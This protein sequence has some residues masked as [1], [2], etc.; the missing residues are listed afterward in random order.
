MHLCGYLCDRSVPES[1]DL[2]VCCRSL[3]GRRLYVTNSLFSP[4]DTQFYPDMAQKGSYLL[5]ARFAWQPDAPCRA[6]PSNPMHHR[7]QT[8]T[9]DRAVARVSQDLASFAAVCCNVL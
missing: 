9:F 3:D 4:W 2:F 5:Q 6:H 7:V 8:R 1:M